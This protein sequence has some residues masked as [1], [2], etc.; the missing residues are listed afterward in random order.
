MAGR[1]LST[2][3]DD[4]GPGTYELFSAVG[5]GA[6]CTASL[7]I[8]CELVLLVGRCGSAVLV[9]VP[10]GLLQGLAQ[11]E[12]VQGPRRASDC[13]ALLFRTMAL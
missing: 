12:A 3:N 7:R 4:W 8:V 2:D 5:T 6:T 13:E 11:E 1:L 9:D 10:D